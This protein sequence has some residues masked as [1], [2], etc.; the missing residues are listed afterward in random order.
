M[1]NIKASTF[2]Q[3]NRH[4]VGGIFHLLV[5]SIMRRADNDESEAKDEAFVFVFWPKEEA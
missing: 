5:Q 2:S 3:D 1:E 4:N